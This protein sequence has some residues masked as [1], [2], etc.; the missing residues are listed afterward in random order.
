MS[1]WDDS[2]ERCLKT[3][4]VQRAS[5]AQGTRGVLVKDNP[6]IRAVVL[7]HGHI[8][9]GTKAADVLEV[10]K[11]GVVSILVQVCTGCISNILSQFHRSILHCKA[12]HRFKS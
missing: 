1:L 7:G 11:D 10:T 12:A 9:V 2:F 4:P 3:Y 8:L 5:L 6:A